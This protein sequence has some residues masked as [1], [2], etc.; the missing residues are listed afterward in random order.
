[1]KS[2][3]ENRPTFTE[4]L[5]VLSVFA[6][7]LAIGYSELSWRLSRW[8]VQSALRNIAN[9]EELYRTSSGSFVACNGVLDCERALA[10]SKLRLPTDINI[11]VDI[12][13]TSSFRAMA[14][15]QNGIMECWNSEKGGLLPNCKTFN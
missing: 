5:V 1:M 13:D 7:L 4:I 9:A 11:I 14:T 12:P 8:R 2:E 3:R 6:V 10:G 15:L